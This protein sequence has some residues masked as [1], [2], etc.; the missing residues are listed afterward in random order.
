MI[1]DEED[2]LR[3]IQ[4]FVKANLNAKITEINVEKGDFTIAT[5][6]AADTHYVFGGDLVEIPNHEFVNFALEPQITLENNQ[7]NI[8]S[9]INMMVEVA[10]D[11]PKSENTYFKSMRYM[12]ALYEVLSEYEPSA[13]EVG[14]LQLTKATPMIV[15][16][17]GRQLAISGVG[18]TVTLG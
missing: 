3:D 7:G 5:I 15:T 10:F 6:K 1:N 8:S 12:R 11:N 4:A 14:G 13:D 16:V 2:L 17:L 9:V 18:I